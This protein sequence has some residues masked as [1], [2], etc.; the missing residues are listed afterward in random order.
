MIYLPLIAIEKTGDIT[1][2][3][4]TTR[5]NKQCSNLSLRFSPSFSLSFPPL[6]LPF[7]GA[8]LYNSASTTM[9]YEPK[10]VIV[11]LFSKNI[12]Q[13]QNKRDDDLKTGF[14]GLF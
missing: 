7:F 13:S 8:Q 9:E 12:C 4:H 1:S 11:P 3:K 5:Q 2:T 14:C 6:F 10:D